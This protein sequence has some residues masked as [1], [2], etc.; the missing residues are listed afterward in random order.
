MDDFLLKIFFL[1][2]IKSGLNV[3]GEELVER[4]RLSWLI[5]RQ[6]SFEQT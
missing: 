6:E 3:G 2:K 4:G 5:G 1:S